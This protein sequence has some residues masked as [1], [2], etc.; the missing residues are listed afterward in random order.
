[1]S[2][3]LRFRTRDGRLLSGGWGGVAGGGLHVVTGT[4]SHLE[5]FVTMDGSDVSIHGGAGEV[6]VM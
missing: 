3:L 6:G 5:T 2:E 1:M 4:P